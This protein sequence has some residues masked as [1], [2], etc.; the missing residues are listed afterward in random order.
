MTNSGARNSVSSDTPVRPWIAAQSAASAVRHSRKR[1]CG[2]STAASLADCRPGRSPVLQQVLELV[3]RPVRLALRDAADQHPARS[4]A[5]EP[6]GRLELVL[7][8][9]PRAAA[10]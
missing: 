4:G 5:E 8:L 2:P 9:E 3:Q 6:A 7:V 10:V 1:R